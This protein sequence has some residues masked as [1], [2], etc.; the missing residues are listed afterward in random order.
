[1]RKIRKFGCPKSA[2]KVVFDSLIKSMFG[3]GWTPQLT[4]RRHSFSAS[5]F[6]LRFGYFSKEENGLLWLAYTERLFAYN[7]VIFPLIFQRPR[8]SLLYYCDF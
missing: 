8:V 5:P 3:C 2:A 1:M 6:G 7:T 4:P